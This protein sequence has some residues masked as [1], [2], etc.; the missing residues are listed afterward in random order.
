MRDYEGFWKLEDEDETGIPEINLEFSPTGVSVTIW[1]PAGA[2][3]GRS[4]PAGPSYIKT[5]DIG[6]FGPAPQILSRNEEGNYEGRIY[7]T[8]ILVIVVR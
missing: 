2:L 1:V 5:E 8:K 6:I 7:E 4:W 3:I